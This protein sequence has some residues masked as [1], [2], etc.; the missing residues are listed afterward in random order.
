MLSDHKTPLKIKEPRPIQIRRLVGLVAVLCGLLAPVVGCDGR[1]PAASTSSSAS[2]GTLTSST[3]IMRVGDDLVRWP[4]FKFWLKHVTDYY[5]A[6]HNLDEIADWS[7]EQQGLPLEEFF[8]QSAAEQAI[9]ARTIEAEAKRR[10]LELSESD[11]AQIAEERDRNISI[12]GSE[13][14]YRRI[15]AGMYYSEDVY[16]YL[17]KIDRYTLALFTDL[18]GTNAEKCT[19]EQVMAYVNEVGLMCAKY[20]FRTDVAPDGT[21]LT[22][23]ESAENRALLEGLISRLDLSADP[24]ALFD[25]LVFDHNEDRTLLAY[26]EGRLFGPGMMGE[27]FERACAA[28][29]EGRYSGV[30]ETESGLYLILRLPIRP[31]MTAD[32]SGVTL[33]YRTAYDYLFQRQIDEWC[34]DMDFDYGEAY[35]LVRVR[36]LFH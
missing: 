3:V 22:A 33:R 10:G 23:E 5:K 4:E 31:D 6:L 32:S 14:E 29:N 27:E 11:M 16:I 34:A 25:S 21:A 30:V 20:I 36:G 26:P 19:D 8:L 1:A 7:V 35:D 28:L 18:Y 12:Y 15:I 24:L 17:Q 9:T 13:S 2:A